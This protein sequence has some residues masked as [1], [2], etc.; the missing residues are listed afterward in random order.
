MAGSKY[1]ENLERVRVP[2]PEKEVVELHRNTRV[3]NFDPYFE[4]QIQGIM[5]CYEFNRYP[6]ITKLEDKIVDFLDAGFSVENIFITSGIDGGIKSTFEMFTQKKS[7]IAFLMPT[8]AMYNVYSRA[9]GVRPVLIQSNPVSLTV[10]LEEISRCLDENLDVLFI[11]NPHS[12]IEN[13]FSENEMRQIIEKAASV[14]T[15]VFVDEAYYMFGSISCMGLIQEFDNLLVARTFSK[16]FGLPA[17]R[18]GYLAGHSNLIRCLRTKSYAYETN[19]I[20]MEVGMWALD[21]VSF[22]VDYCSAICRQRAILKERMI[23]S[24]IPCRG[25]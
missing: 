22:F 7:S 4:K 18:L 1:W 8:Y 12:P 24:G 2:L 9:F 6:D 11:Q 17:I 13:M 25:E 20:S 14:G 16:G 5:P 3:D 15:I 19:S 23:E 10:S 21:N